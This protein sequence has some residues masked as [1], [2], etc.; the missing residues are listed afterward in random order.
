MT[1]ANVTEIEGEQRDEWMKK[2][3]HDFQIRNLITIFI[4]EKYCC[5]H[6]SHYISFRRSMDKFTPRFSLVCNNIYCK[7]KNTFCFVNNKIHNS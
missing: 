6:L 1:I 3:I 5:E 4:T 7:I 2:K